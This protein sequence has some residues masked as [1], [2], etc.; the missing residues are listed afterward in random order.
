MV[1]VKLQ[2]GTMKSRALL[3]FRR[4]FLELNARS[5]DTKFGFEF[6]NVLGVFN[7]LFVFLELVFQG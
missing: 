1:S 4:R 3:V 5:F 6:F 7:E 2:Y